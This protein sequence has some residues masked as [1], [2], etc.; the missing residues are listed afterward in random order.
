MLRVCLQVSKRLT[1]SM[2]TAHAVPR[3]SHVAGSTMIHAALRGA[4][5]V[6][7]RPKQHG[8]AQAT[9]ENLKPKLVR[10]GCGSPP[11]GCMPL[12]RPPGPQPPFI[13]GTRAPAVQPLTVAVTASGAAFTTAACTHCGPSSTATADTMALRSDSTLGAP[14][15]PAAVIL[16][17]AALKLTRALASGLNTG[18]TAAAVP[19]AS[20]CDEAAPLVLPVE[21]FAAAAPATAGSWTTDSRNCTATKLLLT[22][23]LRRDSSAT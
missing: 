18:P 7:S 4:P 21:A 5:R 17:N 16:G 15:Y 6:E 9:G 20:V 14:P 23:G 22:C 8:G 3:A 11:A 19:A 1:L 13:S 12:G 10:S 2:V